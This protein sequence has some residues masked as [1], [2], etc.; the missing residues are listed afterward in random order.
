MFNKKIAVISLGLLY[1]VMKWPDPFDY[2]LKR[3]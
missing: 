3:V 2:N 1:R